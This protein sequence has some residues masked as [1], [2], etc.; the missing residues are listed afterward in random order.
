ML[1]LEETFIYDSITHAYNMA[2]SNYRNEQH[3]EGI[4]EMLYGTV[5]GIMTEEYRL[6]PEAFVR[7]WG[8]EETANMLFRESYTDMS[9]FHPVPMYAF[10]DGLV[11][12]EKAGTVVDRWPDR[13]RSYAAVDPLRD[14]WEETLEEQV[15]AFDPIGV[16]LYPSHWSADHH[17]GWSMGDPDVAFP[18]FEKAADL[19]ID[20][21]DIHKAIPFGPVPRGPYHP[22]DVDVAAE[23][24]PDLTFSIVHGGFAFTEETAWQLARFP[25]VYVNLEG[26]P[27]ILLGNERRFA[28]ILAELI[29]MLGEDGMDRLFWS[30]GAMS[31]HPKPQLEAF[32]DFEFPD[33]VR[34]NTS[35]MGELPQIT[36]EHKRKILGENYA[37]LIGLDIDEA[38][39]RITDDEFARYRADNGLADPYST[40]AVPEEVA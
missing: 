12:N 13:F 3:A 5:D 19:G 11:A 4:T 24:F 26:I 7:D 21:I 27:P 18:V 28:E 34:K 14:G 31:V 30:S 36:D 40:T 38:K 6:E 1:D 10:H 33:D 2:P 32:R 20:L 39:S 15:D 22:R 35:A 29:S 16:K 23:S 37:D 8:V 17:E 25:N 9:T